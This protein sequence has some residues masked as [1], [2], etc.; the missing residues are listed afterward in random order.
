VSSRPDALAVAA[1]LALG[2]CGLLRP[3]EPLGE[4]L[5]DW[6]RQ[7]TVE[8][9]DAHR[10]FEA[11]DG[12]APSVLA[13]G[14]EGLHEAE[15]RHRSGATATVDLF[16][17]TA[18]IG[19]FGLFRFRTN[20][21]QQPLGVGTEGAGGSGSVDFWQG[22]HYAAITTAFPNADVVGLAR[23]VAERLPPGGGLPTCLGLLPAA[24]RVPRSEEWVP[25]D[26]LG[27][28]FMRNVV[29]ADYRIAGRQATVFVAMLSSPA[30]ARDVLRRLRSRLAGDT[31]PEPLAVGEDGFVVPR[32][33]LG[34]VAAFRLGRY[35]GGMLRYGPEPAA[36]SILENLA[37]RLDGPRGS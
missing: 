21:R 20:F 14:F 29:K 30:E 35:L 18:P 25:S 19:A 22:R 8:R 31:A 15:Y 16:E 28:R 11:I 7:G 33:Y 23:A 36:A 10:L 1:V 17:M 26:F 37:D 12:E 9:Y 32:P 2:G 5:G 4:R 24:G 6:R 27:Y 3:R 34:R 13:F